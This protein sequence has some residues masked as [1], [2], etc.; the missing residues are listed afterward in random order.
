M[1]APV[2]NAQQAV[3]GAIALQLDNNRFLDALTD[4]T[5]LGASG[6]TVLAQREQGSDEV[7]YTSPLR[8]LPDAAFRT[9]ARATEVAVPMRNALAGLRG[10]GLARATTRGRRCWPP[11]ATCRV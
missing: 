6:E 7:V 3:V 2:W 1:V 10:G 9:R 11:G 8:G 5:G 4:R